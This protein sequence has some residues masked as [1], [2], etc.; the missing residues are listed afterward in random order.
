MALTAGEYISGGQVRD[1]DGRTVVIVEGGGGGGA[2][3]AQGTNA[4]KPATPVTSFYY[5]TDTTELW[6]ANAGL[7]A[8]QSLGAIAND[9][10][11]YNV[12]SG[13]NFTAWHALVMQG[14]ITIHSA[15]GLDINVAGGGLK[16]AEGSNAK[17]GTF[18]ANGTTNVTVANSSVTA[19]SRILFSLNA[20]SGVPGIMGVVSRIAGTSFTVVSTAATDLGTYAF[21]MFE[22]G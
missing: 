17:Q 4:S 1:A 5:A 12:S 19:T 13:G 7:T 18:V 2:S 6:V 16:V 22:V 10:L 20:I 15:A 3:I 11:D 21:E 8:W 9:G 14:G